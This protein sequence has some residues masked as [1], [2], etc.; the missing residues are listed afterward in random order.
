ML[1]H[2]RH[3]IHFTLYYAHFITIVVHS[4]SERALASPHPDFSPRPSHFSSWHRLPP[5][6]PCQNTRH[7]PSV[8]SSRSSKSNHLT[9]PESSHWIPPQE[10]AF[11]GGPAWVRGLP[12]PVY[13]VHNHGQSTG[14]L[15]WD[16]SRTYLIGLLRGQNQIIHVKHLKECLDSE[17][18]R[19]MLVVV[20]TPST[21]SGLVQA[22]I[23]SD[24]G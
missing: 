23:G 6:R 3:S 11:C 2:R 7:H 1:A 10:A 18:T 19:A 8:P 16:R 5:N 24:L 12:P 20:V 17:I 21:D 4:Y 9:S 13:Y 14:T 22:A 15:I